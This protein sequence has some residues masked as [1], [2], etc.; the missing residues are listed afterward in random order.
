M[1]LTLKYSEVKTFHSNSS[2]LKILAPLFLS[3]SK[4]K[5]YT[6]LNKTIKLYYEIIKNK[7]PHAEEIDTFVLGNDHHFYKQHGYH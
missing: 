2:F 4:Q 1:K 6:T 3:L 7:E 5:I